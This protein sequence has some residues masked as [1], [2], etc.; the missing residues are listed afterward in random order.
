MKETPCPQTSLHSLCSAPD[1]CSCSRGLRV[2]AA[3]D[4]S[5]ATSAAVAAGTI[6][7]ETAPIEDAGS[8]PVTDHPLGG[9]PG[10]TALLGELHVLH[11]LKSGGYGTG[12]DPF[13]NFTAVAARRDQPRFLYALDRLVEKVARCDSLIAQERYDELGEEFKD[14]ASLALCAESMRREDSGPLS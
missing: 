8:F 5:A 7:D 10:Y 13:A 6:T 2:R 4:G 11:K 9:H 3:S 1:S 14:I 12:D